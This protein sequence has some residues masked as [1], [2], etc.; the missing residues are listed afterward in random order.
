[1][2]RK[3]Q[4]REFAGTHSGQVFSATGLAKVLRWKTNAR[5]VIGLARKCGAVVE[6][7]ERTI[8]PQT[9]SEG[10]RDRIVVGFDIRF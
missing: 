8:P 1:M 2:S 4:M 5:S 9:I 6:K 3:N 10:P 7:V